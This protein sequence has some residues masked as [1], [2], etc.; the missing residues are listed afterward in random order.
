MQRTWS[1]ILMG[2]LNTSCIRDAAD[3]VH[4]IDDTTG[5]PHTVGSEPVC[6]CARSHVCVRACVRVHVASVQAIVKAL[7]LRREK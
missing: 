2:L 6:V 4:C 1:S 7:H 3:G 5:H